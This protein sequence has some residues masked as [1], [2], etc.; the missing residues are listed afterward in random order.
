MLWSTY[1]EHREHSGLLAVCC[2]SPVGSRTCRNLAHSEESILPFTQ[3]N[4]LP[5]FSRDTPTNLPDSGSGFH[6]H[7]HPQL[8]DSSQG[9]ALWKYF[10]KTAWI[11]QRYHKFQTV[12]LSRYKWQYILTC[13]QGIPWR[14]CKDPL[15]PD[16][17]AHHICSNTRN[18]SEK[19]KMVRTSHFTLRTS[20]DDTRTSILTSR[21]E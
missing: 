14:L 18:I 6:K 10:E 15:L 1:R 11:S 5:F 4:F 2:A 16:G 19:R 3:W 20:S 21:Q 8:T 7:M 9:K 12:T 17:F 13:Y